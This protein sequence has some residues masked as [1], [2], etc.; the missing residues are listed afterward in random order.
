MTLFSDLSS[1]TGLTS[2]L[3]PHCLWADTPTSRL[4]SSRSFLPG[5]PQGGADA[6]RGQHLQTVEF[7][8]YSLN[9]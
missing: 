8:K 2:R 3:Q 6:G 7:N 4:Q 1:P 9:E 5:A